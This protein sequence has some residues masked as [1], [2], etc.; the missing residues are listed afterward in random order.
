MAAIVGI[1]GSAAWGGTGILNNLL[2]DGSKPVSFSLN[3]PIESFDTTAFD[4]TQEADYTAGLK[5]WS[6]TITCQ[7]PTPS[8]G[9]AASITIPSGYASNVDGWQLQLVNDMH[10]VTDFTAAAAGWKTFIGGLVRG[11]GSYGAF[12]DSSTPAVVPGTISS[13]VFTVI[14]GVTFTA[15]IIHGWSASASPAAPN[16]IEHNF[17][18]DGTITVASSNDVI[19]PDSTSGTGW[20]E[21][22]QTL[23]LTA[24]TSQTFSGSALWTSIGISRPAASPGILTVG[25]RGT[26]AMAVG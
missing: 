12:Y 19:V 18:V 10:E 6:G 2:G 4:V 23:T 11:T 16:R 21:A 8:I 1:T 26:G 14:S 25:F 9:A 13:A 24:S 15:N 3:A 17:T 7:L 5:E 22:A 20:V